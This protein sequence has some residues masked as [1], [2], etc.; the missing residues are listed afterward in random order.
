MGRNGSPMPAQRRAN[1][2]CHPLTRMLYGLAASWRPAAAGDR[3]RRQ[4]TDLMLLLVLPGLMQL[5]N[6]A[7]RQ[8]SHRH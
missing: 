5:L 1:N 7:A 2:C 8:R 4:L 6:V 3:S